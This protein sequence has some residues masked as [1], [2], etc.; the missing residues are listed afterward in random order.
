MKLETRRCKCGCGRTF[1]CLP[2]SDAEYYSFYECAEPATRAW[3]RLQFTGA[4]S[5]EVKA[6]RVAEAKTRARNFSKWDRG[7]KRGASD[8]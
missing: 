5:A 2:S 6:A 3:G 7:R 4:T 1:K 8:S